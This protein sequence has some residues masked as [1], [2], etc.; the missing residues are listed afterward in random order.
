MKILGHD[1]IFKSKTKI[2]DLPLP[3]IATP[4]INMLTAL[5]SWLNKKK[6][7]I[8]QLWLVDKKLRHS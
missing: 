2:F 6:S 7:K 3:A 5:K 8:M 4:I 1:S